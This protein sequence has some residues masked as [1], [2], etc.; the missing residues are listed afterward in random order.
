MQHSFEDKVL[1]FKL[2]CCHRQLSSFPVVAMSWPAA[3]GAL[4][5]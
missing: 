2:W 3:S 5:K 1:D 4:D